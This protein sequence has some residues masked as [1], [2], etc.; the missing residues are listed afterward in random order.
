M[1]DVPVSNNG[2][3][4]RI[5]VY[6]KQLED[7]IRI[8]PPS[9]IGGLTSPAYLKLNPQGKMPI[10]VTT[11]ENTAKED[12]ARHSS[13]ITTTAIVESDT[14]ARFLLSEYAHWKP[15]HSFLVDHPRSNMITRIHD[16]FLTTIQGCLYKPSTTAFGR[17]GH[18]RRDAI[19]EFQKQLLIINDLVV[20][21]P[22]PESDDD[23]KTGV[24]RYLC[25]TEVSLADATLFPTAVFAWHMLPKFGIADALPPRLLDWFH[26]VRQHDADFARVHQ[27]IMGGLEVWEKNQRWDPI[28]ASYIGWNDDDNTEPATLFDKILSGEIP[29]AVVEQPDDTVLCFRD[30]NP[31]APAHVLIVPKDHCGL[32][33]L[34]R[35]TAEHTEILGRL[36]VRTILTGKYHC[37]VCSAPVNYTACV[38]VTHALLL[39]CLCFSDQGGCC[40]HF[41]K[42]RSGFW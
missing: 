7:V 14:V 24:C 20:D 28:L 5:I 34:G 13:A 39:E 12:A 30:I 21:G 19:A 18:S 33:R 23:D 42:Q 6:K 3:R 15:Q 32:T 27:E 10:L 9:E 25:G 22:N 38:M 36:L 2:A 40:D 11:D 8:A 31:A 16:M 35:A 37:R 1:Y 29:A 4:C 41:E 17:F 26:S